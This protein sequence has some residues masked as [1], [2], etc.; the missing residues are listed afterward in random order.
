MAEVA[1]LRVEKGKL[2]E[3]LAKAES[4]LHAAEQRE[5]ELRNEESVRIEKAVALK[6]RSLELKSNAVE[7]TRRRA[8]KDAQHLKAELSETHA[9]FKHK[10]Q[11][12][13]DLRMRAVDELESLRATIQTMKK[14]NNLYAKRTQVL[15]AES[16]RAVHEANAQSQHVIQNLQ[17]KISTLEEQIASNTDGLRTERESR[18]EAETRRRHAERAAKKARD[19]ASVATGELQTVKQKLDT[20]Q[21]RL[22]RATR[23]QRSALQAAKDGAIVCFFSLKFDFDCLFLF[24]VFFHR[25]SH[26][27]FLFLFLFLF[28]PSSSSTQPR[29]RV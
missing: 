9:T 16:G 11:T 18:F 29:R 24:F 14:H 20:L 1:T 19:A 15:E 22:D 23:G 5:F 10:L 25:L 7:S 21:A 26:H 17:S 12:E 4:A 3:R 2:K 6:I 27:L 8:Q 13:R 28:L